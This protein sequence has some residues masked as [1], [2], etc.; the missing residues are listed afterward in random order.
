MKSQGKKILFVGVDQSTKIAFEYAR[1]LGLYII[2][3]DYYPV[4]ESPLKQMADEAWMV[5]ILDID[6]LES[7]AR[8]AE[9]NAI[10]GG[11]SEICLDVV[12]ELAH[13]LQLPFYASDEGWKANRNKNY[14]KEEAR[15][16]GLLVPN[17]YDIRSVE[18]VKNYK[19]HYPII[20]KPI[21]SC[22]RRG[23]SVCQNEEELK[24]AI[25]Q[26]LSHSA[27][28]E[29]VVEDFHFGEE[30]LLA[31]FLKNGKL[32]YDNFI[33]LK[34]NSN[35]PDSAIQYMEHPKSASFHAEI[36]PKVKDLLEQLHMKDG[37]V[38]L[39]GIFSEEQIYF[40]EMGCRYDGLFGW[41]NIS[42]R[43][44]FNTVHEMVKLALGDQSDIITHLNEEENIAVNYFIW[45]NHG[46]ISRLEGVDALKNRKDMIIHLQRYGVG[47]TASDV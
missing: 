26:A 46:K 5:S 27:L 39:Q 42:R 35:R 10:F 16:A 43:L 38:F 24:E 7:M 37:A 14:F 32:I 28:K 8:K 3:A 12:I 44:G 33:Y 11:C 34:G 17:S 47:D 21:D 23:I 4:E 36:L 20:V 22:A 45:M 6:L 15:K 30:I 31:L 1:S 25:P 40:F 18:D 41:Y 29:L 9:I 13:R 19:F 2:I